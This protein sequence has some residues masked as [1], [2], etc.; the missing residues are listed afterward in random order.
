VSK[1]V[2]VKK[3]DYYP[4]TQYLVQL[5]QAPDVMKKTLSQ[6]ISQ[7]ETSSLNKAHSTKVI[8]I[9]K[10]RTQ[11]AGGLL[12]LA[13]Q[14]FNTPSF[15]VWQDPNSVFDA[16]NNGFLKL[17]G[18]YF[19]RP[20]PKRPRHGFLESR[21]I[22]SPE[23]L[24]EI[25]RE[26]LKLDPEGEVILMP[27]IDS[28]QSAVCTPTQITIG[29]GHDGA[30]GGKSGAFVFPLGHTSL[31]DEIWA[32]ELITDTVY[33]ESVKAK[34]DQIFFVQLRDGP[35]VAG[36]ITDSWIPADTLVTRVLTPTDDM[37]EWEKLIN[38]AQ[39]GDVAHIP[40][41]SMVCHAAVHCV[42]N[43][44][45]VIFTSTPTL[46]DTLKCNTQDQPKILY[47]GI[48]D[49]L[50]RGLAMQFDVKHGVFDASL[51]GI[52]QALSLA[53]S[54]D[55]ARAV[56]T[57]IATI[58]RAAVACCIGET[59]YCSAGRRMIAGEVFA[60]DDH[61][62]DD[63][64]SED[65]RIRSR[66]KIYVELFTDYSIGRNLLGSCAKIYYDDLNWGSGAYGGMKWA[67][68]VAATHN[69]DTLM[70]KFI[71]DPSEGT[72]KKLL[73][74]AHTLIN[75][76]HNGG[77]LLSKV[78]S[79]AQ[80]EEAARATIVPLHYAA[81]RMTKWLRSQDAR[82]YVLVELPALPEKP[83]PKIDTGAMTIYVRQLDNNRL[84]FQLKRAGVPSYIE[85][86]VTG[87]LKD[88][89]HLLTN[90]MYKSMHSDSIIQYHRVKA[91]QWKQLPE[92]YLAILG[93]N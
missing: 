6:L 20:C 50:T 85:R 49:G 9:M 45:P 87:S 21:R 52:H 2:D 13:K 61:D 68:C 71:T 90:S 53:T 79:N 3:Y 60:I 29:L 36:G 18:I 55:G 34:N 33:M 7:L 12:A 19:A 59:R 31:V 48:V 57:S 39:P 63:E 40:G 28:D 84:R 62:E 75:V 22:T 41:G 16:I 10:T 27:Y 54:F 89:Q 42:L 5:S 30:T 93:L 91:G 65:S 58:L 92:A 66:S 25:V 38:A 37:L 67:D 76:C 64:A 82:Q 44:V 72:F 70:I 80:F 1:I 81:Y 17:N 78:I 86:D 4:S 51:F 83:K 23:Q 26:T 88:I 56:G 74:A 24:S 47:D 46:G 8:P 69:L 43:K 73:G 35:T 14:D 77:P 15:T 32:K 11:K